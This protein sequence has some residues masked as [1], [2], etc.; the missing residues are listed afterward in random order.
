[1]IP[2]TLETI[3]TISVITIFKDR[4]ETILVDYNTIKEQFYAIEVLV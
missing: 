4:A 2:A 3:Y 1:M